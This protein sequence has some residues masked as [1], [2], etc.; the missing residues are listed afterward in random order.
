MNFEDILYILTE[1]FLALTG[2]EILRLV[3]I[4]L[5]L[6]FLLYIGIDKKRKATIVDLG[7]HRWIVRK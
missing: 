6:A 7:Y 3:L 1:R 5:L 4:S 2:A